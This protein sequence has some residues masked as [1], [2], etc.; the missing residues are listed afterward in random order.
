MYRVAICRALL[1]GASAAQTPPTQ[2]EPPQFEVASIRP[3]NPKESADPSGCLNTTGLL[4]CSNVTL[5]RCIV[6]AYGVGPDRVLN[7][8]DWINTELS[9]HRAIGATR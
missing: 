9:D 2:S 6:G 8:P 4:R 5:K 1:V 3:T 7:G